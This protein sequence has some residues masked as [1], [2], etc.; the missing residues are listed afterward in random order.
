[1]GAQGWD[2]GRFLVNLD[3]EKTVVNGTHPDF[4]AGTPQVIQFEATG[5]DTTEHVL[6]ITNHARGPYGSVLEVDALM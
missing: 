2:H 6:Y 3:G 1:M 4:G 5:L